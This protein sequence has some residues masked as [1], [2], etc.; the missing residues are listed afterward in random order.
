[1]SCGMWCF[2]IGWAVPVLL[3]AIQFFGMSVATGP[4]T[5]HHI[6][7][8]SSVQQH[9]YHLICLP[10]S[11]IKLHNIV[12][13]SYVIIRVACFGL[14]ITDTK[15]QSWYSGTCD[16]QRG[17]G[18]GFCPGMSFLAIHHS[19]NALYSYRLWCVHDKLAGCDSHAGERSHLL[20]CYT[21]L[22]AEE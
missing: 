7:V 21:M 2:S 16:G 14:I 19:F 4:V 11:D 13:N 10:S 3:K 12:I 9:H 5:W 20:W 18:G 8:R 22:T 15:I 6:P 17:T 1:M